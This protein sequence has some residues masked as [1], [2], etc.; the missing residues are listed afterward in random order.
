MSERANQP[1]DWREIRMERISSLKGRLGWQGLKAGEYRS[2]GPHVVSSAHFRKQ[3]IVWS[4]CPRV[5]PER[6]ERDREI[7]LRTEDVLLMKDGAAM[8][9]VA[10]VDKLPGPACLNSHL[11][12]F[13]PL[14]KGYAPKFLFY[15]L[16]SHRF[17][18]YIAVHGTGVTF[19][20]ISQANIA[21]YRV[22]MPPLPEQRCMAEILDTVDE[23]IRKTEEIIAKLKQVKQ[24]LLHDLLTRGIDD[25]GELRDP[26]RHP[27]QFKDS[28]LG[29]IPKAW[30]V[31][32]AATWCDRLTVGVVSSATHAYID[33]GVPFIRSQNV[34]A[35][36]FDVDDVLHISEAF[37]KQHSKSILRAGDVAIVRTG[38]PGTAAVVPK[39]L[40]GSNCFSLVIAS[41]RA[42][43][44]R[45]HFLAQ[46]LNSSACK[47]VIRR[48]QFGSAQH[49]FNVGEMRRL[50][51]PVP[52]CGEQ[53][54]IVQAI[55]VHEART[56][57]EERQLRKLRALKQGLMEDLLTGRVRVARF[58]ESSE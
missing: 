1:D 20:G 54:V 58:L 53:D 29:R 36:R 3:R 24:G 8:G 15:H 42:I 49:N 21:R 17:Q 28:P 47:A 56:R 18:Q 2:H 22:P 13:R 23:A 30:Q 32:P 43:E 50:L 45:S 38:Y 35:N 52:S 40:D 16:T 46:Y 12:L 5:T 44:L 26:E 6:Y 19:L 51:M 57:V 31:G 11:L 39:R 9:K 41:P 33:A 48:M 55:D 10:Y 14:A 27:E 4:M 37:N 34:K 25:N 7:Q